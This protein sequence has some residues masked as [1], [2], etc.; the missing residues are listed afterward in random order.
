MAVITPDGVVARCCDVVEGSS[1]CLD[2]D[3]ETG[4]A[5]RFRNKSRIHGVIARTKSTKYLDWKSVIE[6]REGCGPAKRRIYGPVSR[7]RFP[8]GTSD[9]CLFPLSI[10]GG[11]REGGV[12][13]AST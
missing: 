4:V 6:R 5:A 7:S 11:F 8:K 3:E 10:R 12:D 2:Q 9:R 13:P 1:Q